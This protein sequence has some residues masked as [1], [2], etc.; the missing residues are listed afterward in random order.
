MGIV[1][2]V[3]SWLSPRQAH[4]K[5][6]CIVVS[7]KLDRFRNIGNGT[8]TIGYQQK[9]SGWLRG[10]SSHAIAVVGGWAIVPATWVP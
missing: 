4:V 10:N 6:I 1:D 8:A 2:R 5:H 9:A 3:I 7:G